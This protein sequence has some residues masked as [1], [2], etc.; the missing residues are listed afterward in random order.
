MSR[1]MTML[2][3]VNQVLDLDELGP[4]AFSAVV[5]RLR[6]A[7]VAHVACIEPIQN[8]AL[9]PRTTLAPARIAPLQIHLFDVNGALPLRAVAREVRPAA[10]LKSAER[11]AAEDGFQAAGG[12]AVEGATSTSGASGSVVSSLEAPD[13]LAFAAEAD[14]ATVLV[15]RDAFAAGW[16]ATVNGAPAPLL[17]ADGRHRAIPIP[18]GRSHV[19]LRYRPVGLLGAL[20][21]SLLCLAAIARAFLH[22]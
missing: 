4:S 1:D 15:V 7:G 12:V 20:G 22:R 11:I 19:V 14:R 2:V 13:R 5:D 18:A 21:L 10:D 17:R 9:R 6:R 3:P 8:A 16:T